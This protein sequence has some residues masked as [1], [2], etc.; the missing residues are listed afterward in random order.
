MV[1]EHMYLLTVISIISAI[2]AVLQG[3]QTWKNF[4]E[5]TLAI[6]KF[7]NEL[8]KEYFLFYVKWEEGTST[9]AEVEKFVES[10]ENLYD[11]QINEMLDSSSN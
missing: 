10:V 4:E 5:Q 9:K 3:L 8:E 11:E 7:I 1:P 6:S 2:V